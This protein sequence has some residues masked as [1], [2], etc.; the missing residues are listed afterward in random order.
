MHTIVSKSPLL[1][2]RL[3]AMEKEKGP[4]A[5]VINV[6]LPANYGLPPPVAAQPPPLFQKPTGLIPSTLSE[7][8]RMDIDTFCIVYLLPDAILHHFRDNAITGTHAFSHIAETDLV[9]MGFKIGEV[10]DLK[11]A[12]KMWA[13]SK[14]SF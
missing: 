11:E 9:G 4:Q 12:V 1:T 2:S 10:I 5:P 14:E 6:V 13:S 3:K 7:G 8:P